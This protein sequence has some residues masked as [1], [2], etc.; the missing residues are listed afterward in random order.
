MVVVM[1][2]V[3]VVVVAVVVVSVVRSY[4]GSRPSW[5]PLR[6]GSPPA[7]GALGPVALSVASWLRPASSSSTG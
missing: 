6:G 2:V 7:P 1:V 3:V 4:L 5:V